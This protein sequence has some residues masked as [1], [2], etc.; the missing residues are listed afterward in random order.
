M[1]S[2]SVRFPR[3]NEGQPL[4]TSIKIHRADRL[5]RITGIY[6]PLTIK[7]GDV[8]NDCDSNWCFNENLSKK[9]NYKSGGI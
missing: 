5:R 7:Y 8:N 1:F 6:K 2:V 4:I 9:R 3:L